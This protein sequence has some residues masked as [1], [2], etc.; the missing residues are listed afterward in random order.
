MRQMLALG[1]AALAVLG[2]TRVES[3]DEDAALARAKAIE[4]R[5]RCMTLLDDVEGVTSVNYAGAGKDYRLLVVVRDPAARSA[6][7]RKTGG[8]TWEGIPILWSVTHPGT[9]TTPSTATIAAPQEGTPAA[10]KTPEPAPAPSKPQKAAQ[11]TADVPDCDIVRAQMG[12]PPVHHMVGGNSWKS[13]T[14]CQVWLRAVQGPGGGHSY[15]YTK[16]RPGCPF[17]DG[18]ASA[19]YR[20]GFLYPTELRGSDL[21]WGRQVRQD[22]ESKFPPPAPPMQPKSTP[23]R[24]DTPS[25]P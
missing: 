15:L 11:P 22:L 20:E 10:P 14:P 23:Y 9:Y 25:K 5:G 4:L 24:P 21:S 13:W 1:V 6:A 18:L 16:H 8:D 17:Q 2:A 7:R 12:L 3:Q 19:V